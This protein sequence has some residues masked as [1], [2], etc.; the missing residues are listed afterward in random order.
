LEWCRFA[1]VAL[2]AGCGSEGE[3][4]AAWWVCGSSAPG[5]GWWQGVRRCVS[6]LLLPEVVLDTLAVSFSSQTWLHGGGKAVSGDILEEHTQKSHSFKYIERYILEEHTQKS[7][8]KNTLYFRKYK[9][10]KF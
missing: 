6:R 7:L 4:K 5:R 3:S 9:K 8:I 10:D 2:P 1:A